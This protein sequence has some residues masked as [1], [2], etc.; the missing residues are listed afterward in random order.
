MEAAAACTNAD[1]D[2]VSSL[3][4]PGSSCTASAWLSHAYA[5]AYAMQCCV[6]ADR[7]AKRSHRHARASCGAHRQRCVQGSCHMQQQ[8]L[9]HSWRSSSSSHAGSQ[10]LPVSSKSPG[11]F[12]AAHVAVSWLGHPL[13][14]VM[15]C[16][17]MLCFAQVAEDYRTDPQLYDKCKDSVEQLCSDV[18]PGSGGELDCLVSHHHPLGGLVWRFRLAAQHAQRGG[19]C[20]QQLVQHH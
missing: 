20:Q 14:R 2:V 10:P 5:N 19:R 4:S 7:A 6:A 11:L 17:A 15:L 18:E 3:A 1:W 12:M 9:P 16:C 8:P 13:R